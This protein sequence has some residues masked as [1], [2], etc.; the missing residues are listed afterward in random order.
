MPRKA[1][2]LNDHAFKHIFQG[3]TPESKAALI[4][5]ISIC[6]GRKIRDVKVLNTELTNPDEKVKN[7]RLDILA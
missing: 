2:L 6:L 7:P 4:G 3:N 1:D 5:L